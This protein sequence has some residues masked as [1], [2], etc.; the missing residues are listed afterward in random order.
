MK[1]NFSFKNPIKVEAPTR[2]NFEE[3]SSK[4]GVLSYS[5]DNKLVIG[6]RTNIES[7]P[8]HAAIYGF[9]K[10]FQSTY[11]C[12]GVLINERT[13]VTSASCVKSTDLNYQV[14]FGGSDL[15]SV[16]DDKSFKVNFSSLAGAVK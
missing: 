9:D 13:V 14:K 4:C 1:F 10:D 12:G 2:F 3:T 15:F 16:G 8:W 5:Q 11:R 6:D 7:W